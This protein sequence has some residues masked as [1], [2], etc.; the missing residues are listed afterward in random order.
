MVLSCTSGPMAPT[1]SS[2]TGDDIRFRIRPLPTSICET[3]ST[4]LISSRRHHTRSAIS[5]RV[6]WHVS[7]HSAVS[8]VVAT[9]VL[10]L[11]DTRTISYGCFG[12]FLFMP[13]RPSLGDDWSYLYCIPYLYFIL[14]A[15]HVSTLT[16]NLPLSPMAP[17]KSIPRVGE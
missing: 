16:E 7:K 5:R 13:S 10:I 17:C 11:L 12:F 14:R 4:S 3:A 6:G 8:Q 9:F 2:R 1:A 15:S